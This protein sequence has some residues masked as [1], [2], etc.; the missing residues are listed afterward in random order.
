MDPAILIPTPD[1]IPVHWGWF[2]F[3]L[4]LTFMLHM[5]FMNAMLGSGLIAMFN[6]LRKKPENAPL[7]HDISRSLTYTIAFTINMGVAPLL[8]LQVLYGHFMYASSVLMAVYWLSVV[9][10]VI[11]A[12]YSA[13]IYNFNFEQLGANRMKFMGVTVI[14]LLVIAFIF[15]NNMTLMLT[16]EAW[17]NYFEHKG[18]TFLNLKE[19]TL[20]PRYLHFVFASIAV[21]GLLIAIRT[22]LRSKKE[23]KETKKMISYGMRWF[24]FGTAAESGIGII[25]LF[26]LPEPIKMM[27]VGG[28]TLYTS[29]FLLS[30]VGV[31][32]CFVYGMKEKVWPATWALL[33]TVFLM[34]VMRDLARHAYLKPYFTPADLTVVSQYSPMI[35][36]FVVL[37]IG[38]LIVAYMLKLA[39]ES[40]KEVE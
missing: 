3:L 38:L 9:G 32:Y 36:F 13:Y 30:L 24:T 28:S 39:Y 10:L 12:Y 16:P 37:V 1:P 34:I 8:F 29:I 6:D 35:T 21:G 26:S 7:S 40:S 23:D 33:A 17:P 5:L 4:L 25:F 18:G 20:V 19:P 22:T 11:L 15:T 2:Q 27:F 31:F 14:L